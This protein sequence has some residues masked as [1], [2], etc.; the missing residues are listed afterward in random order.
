MPP[1]TAAKYYS[2]VDVAS[3]AFLD[4]D[5]E[6]GFALTVYSQWGYNHAEAWKHADV[7]KHLVLD[8]QHSIIYCQ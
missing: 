5:N 8:Q 4:S 3:S 1:P 6:H 7:T 2:F